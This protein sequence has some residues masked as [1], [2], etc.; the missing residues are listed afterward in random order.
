MFAYIFFVIA[1]L[2]VVKPVRNSLFL[3]HLGI[4]S[5]PYAFVLVAIASGAVVTIYTKFSRTIRVHIMIGTSFAITIL[6]LLFFRFLLYYSVIDAWFLY[7]FYVWVAIFG[8]VL[9]T[10]FWLLANYIFNARE[11]KRLFGLIGSGAI[12]GGIFG[13]YLTNFLAPV[14]KSANLLFFSMGFL[15]L[16]FIVFTI[17]WRRTG[18]YNYRDRIEAQKRTR[19]TLITDNPFK[20]FRK[21]RHLAYTAV[22]VGIGVISANLVDYQYSAIASKIIGNE[23]QLTAFF[24][25]WLSNLSVAALAIQ[26]LFTGKI[27]KSIGA[28]RSLL[29]LP[30]GILAGAIATMINPVLWSAVLIKVSE[31]GFKHS[32]NKAGIELLSMPIPPLVKNQA[33]TIIGV[34]ID[35]FAMGIGGLLLIILTLETGFHIEYISVI[36]FILIAIWIAV[37]FRMKIEYINSFRRAIERR[38][39]DIEEQSLKQADLSMFQSVLKYL[40]SENDRQI[41]YVL[42][43]LEGA[44]NDLLLP[45]LKKLIRHP[46][47]EIRARVLRMISLYEAEDF[48]AEAKTLITDSSQDVRI[49]AISY[50]CWRSDKPEAMLREFLSQ[51]SIEVRTSALI[52]AARA[53]E[54]GKAFGNAFELEGLIKDLADQIE[55]SGLSDS[56]RRLLKVNIAKII[57][58]VKIPELNATLL[59]LLRDKSTEILKAAVIS[60]GETRSE[61]FIPILIS[62]LG[63]RVVAIYARES[64]AG[65][66]DRVIDPLMQRFRDSE[67]NMRVRTRIPKILALIGSKKAVS[68]LYENL[69]Q[70]VLTLRYE[71]IRGLNKLREHYPMLKLD[72][73]L[74]EEIILTEAENYYR[75]NAILF[76]FDRRANRLIPT[77]FESDGNRKQARYLIVRALHESMAQSMERIFRLLSLN[78]NSRDIYNAYLGITSEKPNLRADTVEFLDNILDSNL[79]K[80]IIPI[81][82]TVSVR[83]L[84]TYTERLW[85]FR[86]RSTDEGLQLLLNSNNQWLVVCT[87]YFIA[88]QK[89]ERFAMAA[90]KL[91]TAADRVIAETAS[92]AVNRLNLAG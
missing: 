50:T 54:E 83:S 5:L 57:G 18:E 3:I 34:F 29:F 4:D 14:L 60:A 87:L 11:A 6:S 2:M 49:E 70:D 13:G 33:K 81:V 31:G 91:T 82:E 78:H 74:I 75:M 25:F 73:R 22:L 84:G 89:N 12:L 77:L 53:I 66:G 68:A 21:S 51:S 79:K 37:I 24:G 19:E 76:R 88:E 92:Y 23:D 44:R 43:L 7:L 90:R 1:A 85:D 9:T 39:L 67:E 47:S 20:L 61:E 69:A 30:F 59:K 46:S 62:H 35:S 32:I 48:T 80:Y 45:H 41:L 15:A 63:T 16:S 42:N 65:Y 58:M 10:Q 40:D 72:S 8:V 36:I 27:L 55:W 28:V 56:Q 52:C 17:V 86:L 64:L 38:T 71:T 26:L